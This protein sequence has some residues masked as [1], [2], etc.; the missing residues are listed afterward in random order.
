M[1]AGRVIR[2]SCPVE[3]DYGLVA[4]ARSSNGPA[5]GGAR[6]AEFG[7]EN[8]PSSPSRCL[9]NAVQKLRAEQRQIPS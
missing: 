4:G 9:V 2:R 8:S 6:V 5:A 3:A 7:G 1:I